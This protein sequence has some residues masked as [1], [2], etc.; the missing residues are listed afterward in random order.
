FY[1]D[2]RKQIYAVN[3][4][5]YVAGRI[6]E[7]QYFNSD[8]TSDLIVTMRKEFDQDLKG[9]LILGQN[10]YSKNLENLYATGDDLVIPGF[11]N[12]SNATTLNPGQSMVAKRTAAL[13]AD[14]KLEY[15]NYL[16]VNAT[17][18]NE[19]STTLP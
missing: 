9:S 3:S 10:M 18:R 4:N 7:D 14:A 17:L 13:Y 1:S 11:Y 6:I 12:M 19:W 5:S 8:L 15:K 2:R 16:Y